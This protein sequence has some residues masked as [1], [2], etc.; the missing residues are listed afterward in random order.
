MKKIRNMKTARKLDGATVYRER[1]S[2]ARTVKLG[3][4]DTTHDWY[5]ATN[6]ETKAVEL[7]TPTDL[8]GDYLV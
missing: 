6:V 7:L 3:N 4:F 1:S 5:E 2:D 8:V